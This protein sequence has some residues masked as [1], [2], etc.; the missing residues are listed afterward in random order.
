M[1]DPSL[2]EPLR[3]RRVPVAL[4]VVVAVLVLAGAGVVAV[5]QGDDAGS[6]APPPTTG[7]EPPAPSTT[8]TPGA[9]LS[10]RQEATVEALKAQVSAIR[11][12]SWTRP[13]R[14]EV[15]SGDELARRV[16]EHTRE[17]QEEDRARLAGDEATMKLLGLIPDDIDY[18][19]T[20]DD[21]FAG[22]V[23][24]FYDDETKE[25]VVGGDPD[26]DL[27]VATRS[28]MVHELTHAL[29]DQ[30]FDYGPPTK[31]L[32]DANRTEELA[33]YLA[34]LEGDAELVA[35]LWAERHL[36]PRDQVEAFFG[37][38][39][40]DPLAVLRAPDYLVDA[41]QF[42][43]EDGLDFVRSR[44]DAGG[45]AAVDA[46][47]R[48]PPT[49]TEHVLHPELY[50]AGQGSSPPALP[51]LAAATGCSAVDT[52]ALG[53]FDMAKVLGEHVSTAQADRA[54]AGWNGDVFGVVRCGSALGL[55]DRWRT[56]GPGDADELVRA[57]RDWAAGWS[58]SGQPVDA[59]GR[60]SG[61]SGA[62][63]IV[64]AGTGVDLVLADD[65]STA[66]RVARVLPAV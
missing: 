31:A 66:D 44:Y 26:E 52:G 33:G 38:A 19:K 42:P 53:E 64:R 29:T 37:Q 22:G 59:G 14:I 7:A 10:A 56:D 45:F 25:L 43:Y 36:S 32:D 6:P 20:L 50:D 27:D 48:R 57:L 51:D 54:A 2:P 8:T 34:L 1:A 24:G 23:L 61:P 15:V 65:P 41:L 47:Y 3:G 16:R 12:L 58:G 39:A 55:A 40:G 13:L 11:G 46:A 21:L 5:R 49:S 60:F 4:V 35:E 62:G 63:R 28:V 18:A 30:H 9:S 17:E